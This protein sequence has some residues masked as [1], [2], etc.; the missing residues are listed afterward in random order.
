MKHKRE[1]RAQFRP[2]PALREWMKER[3]LRQYELAEIL[4]CKQ[5]QVSRYLSGHRSLPAEAVVTLANLTGIPAEKLSNNPVTTRLL[6]LLGGR[7]TSHAGL[8]KDHISV[9]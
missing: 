3:G 2:V 9:S 1:R 4:G 8:P 7:T 5:G 6:K